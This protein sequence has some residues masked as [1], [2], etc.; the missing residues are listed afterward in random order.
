MQADT[1][2]PFA[3]LAEWKTGNLE[4]LVHLGIAAARARQYERGLVFLAEAYRHLGR[5][6]HRLSAPLLSHYGLCLA[7]HRGRIKEAIEYCTIGLDRDRFNADAYHNMACVWFAGRSRRKAVEAIEKG[8]SLDPNHKGLLQLRQ[9]IGVRKSPVIP[10]LHRDN[11]L[12]VS[13][14]KMRAR[15]RAK[16]AGAG[17]GPGGKAGTGKGPGRPVR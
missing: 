4:D 17:T 13:L 11:P 15:M 12:N 6:N 8:L 5:E 2:S 3:V 7:L 1:L 14:G 16:K 9:D 10:F